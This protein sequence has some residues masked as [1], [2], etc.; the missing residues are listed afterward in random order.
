MKFGKTLKYSKQKKPS[1]ALISE[2]REEIMFEIK[3]LRSEAIDWKE[4]RLTA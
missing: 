4:N 2:V 3:K 1:H